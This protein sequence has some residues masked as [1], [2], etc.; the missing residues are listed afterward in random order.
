M[1]NRPKTQYSILL[2]SATEVRS[3]E[4]QMGKC[5]LGTW[6]KKRRRRRLPFA[7]SYSWMQ[8]KLVFRDQRIWMADQDSQIIAQCIK[9]VLPSRSAQTNLNPGTS[10]LT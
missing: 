1:I 2:L 3:D 5:T 9:Y 8:Q 7:I 6:L 4:K 10:A